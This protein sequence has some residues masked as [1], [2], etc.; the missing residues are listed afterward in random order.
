MCI[1]QPQFKAFL[2]TGSQE[3]ENLRF[4][5]C[6][7][8]Q[9]AEVKSSLRCIHSFHCWKLDLFFPLSDFTRP[10]VDS[11]SHVYEEVGDE[12][13]YQDILPSSPSLP[14]PL[15]DHR[16]PNQ[17]SGRRAST[18]SQVRAEEKLPIK[19]PLI[20]GLFRTHRC[21]Y[22]VK[23]WQG[24]CYTP[25]TEVQ[26]PLSAGCCQSERSH[27]C[28]TTAERFW[29]SLWTTGRVGVEIQSR[30]I[31]ALFGRHWCASDEWEKGCFHVSYKREIPFIPH[32][33][34]KELPPL[35]KKKENM[36]LRNMKM[37]PKM[38]LNLI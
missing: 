15:F 34:F 4:F 30:K 29:S 28:R 5:F 25:A 3:L 31:A 21:A 22:K 23:C 16:L 36:K 37:S 12:R 32:C 9:T 10:P 7:R 24:W 11:H 1:L 38:M 17:R 18:R 27:W 33:I 13:V 6:L 19:S 14:P 26:S 8:D 20:W 2:L 35:I